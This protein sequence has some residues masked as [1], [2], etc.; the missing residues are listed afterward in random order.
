MV[1][2]LRYTLAYGSRANAEL[3]AQGHSYLHSFV[4]WAVLALGLGVALFVRRVTGVL[5]SGQ[6]G[7]LRTQSAFALWG[8]VTLVLVGIYAAQESL[9]EL[10]A[11]SRPTGLSGLFGHGGWWSVP[12]AAVVALVV[13]AVLRL[14]R[15]VLL[16][17][18]RLARRRIGFGT[19]SSSRPVSVTVVALCPLARSAAGRAPPRVLH[20]G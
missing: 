5:R 3:T 2:Q 1:H 12:A 10:F 14:G 4:P 9:E 16:A 20:V 18:S 17:A 8:L 6:T 13:V 11:T 19:V 15:S 7:R